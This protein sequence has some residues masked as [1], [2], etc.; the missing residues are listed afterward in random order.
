MGARGKLVV[1]RSCLPR[2]RKLA[3]QQRMRQEDRLGQV[4]SQM[5]QQRVSLDLE[6]KAILSDIRVLSS[7]VRCC[8]CAYVGCSLTKSSSGTK[9]VGAS[10]NYS[11]P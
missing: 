10:P 3:D 6:R 9:D 4:I 5:E 8:V 11:S 1:S 2:D 7:E